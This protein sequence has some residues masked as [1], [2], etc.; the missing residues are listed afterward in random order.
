MDTE[1][2]L[3]GD[4]VIEQIPS[5]KDKALRINL[6]ENIYGTF[7]EIGAGQETVRHFFRAG[8]SSGTIAKATSAYDKDFS[9]VIYGV[10]EDGR[11]VT[12]SRL[13]KMLSHEVELIEKRLSREKHP[14]KMFFSYANTVATIDFA[15][16]FKG[17]GWV[18]IRYQIEPNEEY[19]DIILHI[20]FKET[21]VRLQQETLG[22]LGVNLIYGAYYKNNDPK[23]LLRYL[24]DHLDKDQLEI[25]TIN[26]SGPRFAQVD[27]RLMSLQLVKN[28]MT[29]AVIFDP[30]GRNILPAAILY[31]KNI[32]ALRGSFRPVT[33][34]NMDMYE[35]SLKMFLNENKVNPDNTL[36]IFEITLSNLRSDGEIDERDF[37][38]RAELLCSLGQTVMISNFQEYYRV[39]E[40]FSKY[41]KARMGLAM[42]VNNLVDI[43]DE[44]YYRHLSGG[45]LEAFGKL[46][47]RDMKVYLYPMLDEK[48]EIMNSE[49]LRVHPRM[50]ELYKFFKFNGKVV[51]IT[52]FNPKNL[53]VFSREVLKMIS[54]S[55]SGWETMLPTGV[56][57]IIKTHQL[58]G[59]RPDRLFEKMN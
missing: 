46:F 23:R 45:I 5:I 10:E 11:Y 17:H 15:K 12:E 6:N 56:A 19:N 24:Y 37:M 29:D 57:E 4:K 55:K 39:V 8:G 34:V 32:L 7:A 52:N 47:F 58:F 44:K 49:T 30:Q 51:D 53:E 18:G 33:K 9:D 59:Y 27:N 40:Y 2:K 14:N 25:D 36:V 3:K 35:E 42:G 21:D 38:D 22:V 31:K 50:K 43:F 48:G 13:K 1:I 16:Q 41:T 26:F 20:R 28:G 54:E